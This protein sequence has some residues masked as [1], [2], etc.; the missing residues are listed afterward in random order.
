V[1]AKYVTC[2][3][4]DRLGNRCTGEAVMADAELLICTR[5]LAEAQRLIHAA[6]QRATGKGAK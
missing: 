3:V 5:H 4:V 6:Y 1:T 2:R